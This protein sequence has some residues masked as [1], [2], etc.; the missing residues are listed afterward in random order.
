LQATL[1]A[2][3]KLKNNSM[4]LIPIPIYQKLLLSL[5]ILIPFSFA[6]SPTE[7]IDLNILKLYIPIIFLFWLAHSLLHK[8]IIL[9]VRLRFYFLLLFFLIVF[10]SFFWS[11]APT[12]AL[13]KILFFSTTIPLYFAF[14]TASLN[15]LFKIRLLK[16]LLLG[17]TLVA[18]M[19]LVFFALQFIIGLNS[20][21][22]I[23]R[24]YLAPIFLGSS[25]SALVNQYS[26]WL[27]NIS[28]KT[29]L[30]TFGTFPDP[31]LFSLY[32]SM[33]LPLGIYFYEKLRTK[34]YLFF[35]LIILLSISLSYSRAA[36]LAI[37]FGG[38]FLLINSISKDFFKKKILF[39]YGIFVFLLFLFIIPNP[40]TSRLQSSFDLHEGSNN[41]RIEMWQ[42]AINNIK[43]EPLIGLGLGGFADKLNSSLGIRNPIYA[44]NLL[45]DFGAETGLF[46]MFILFLLLLSP[47]LSYLNYKR[48]TSSDNLSK[49]IATSFVIFFVHS[50]F[51][52][53]FFSIRVFPLFLILLA[54]SSSSEHYKNN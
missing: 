18:I 40:L 19:S 53:P 4:K 47:I 11:T 20:T 29:I 9:D 52:T 54:M 44:H 50:L 23:L 49:F 22:E 3:A 13:R 5:G 30:R 42:T 36:Y 14:Y 51:E 45:L 46:N 38:L 39:F 7:T 37:I 26:S 32:L 15:P 48:L 28:G 21:L 41:G 8:K 2:F 6:L 24:S 31:H 34:K 17:A 12:T 35:S 1:Q 43:Q 16:M 27:V 10:L 25:L 33:T